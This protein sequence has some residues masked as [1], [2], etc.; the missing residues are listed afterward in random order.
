M[1]KKFVSVILLVDED[2][3]KTP[4]TIIYNGKAYEIDRVLDM[5]KSA[6]LKVGGIGDKYIIRIGGVETCVFCDN[7]RWFVEEKGR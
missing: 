1:N 4:K 6:S 3:K 5:K 2:G 7:N